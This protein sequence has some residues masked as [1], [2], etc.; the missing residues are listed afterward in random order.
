MARR[1]IHARRIL[2]RNVRRLRD[3]R[4]WNQEVLADAAGLTQSQISK[5]EGADL[6]LTIDTLQDL[7]MGLGKRVAEL[8]EEGKRANFN[9]APRVSSK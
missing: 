8:F 4:G 7:A 5:I 9:S 6:N 1:G 2:A 3:E